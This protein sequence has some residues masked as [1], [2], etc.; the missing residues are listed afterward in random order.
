MPAGHALT[1]CDTVAKVGTKLAMLKKLKHCNDLIS[2]FGH[3]R[4][5]GI[6]ISAAEQ[7]LVNVIMRSDLAE[8]KT[9]DEIRLQ[10]Y[11]HMKKK[12]FVDLPCSS[13]A[14]QQNIKRAYMQTKL[15]IEAPFGNAGAFMDPKQYGFIY[16]EES[17]CL[18][19]ILFDGICRP[20][21]VPE[22][23]R[24]KGKVRP[25]ANDSC[26]CRQNRISCNKYCGCSISDRCQ[27]VFD[28]NR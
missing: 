16:K 15:W 7:F 3:D 20:Q 8:C 13:N 24:C 2:D 28:D 23:C 4:L 11:L 10:S 6:T 12:K 9:F 18:D 25:C 27:N 17:D 1:G 22:P 14:I 26:K 19:P 5:D 21:D